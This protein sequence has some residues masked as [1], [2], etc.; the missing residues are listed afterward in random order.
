MKT[1]YIKEWL[2]S[3][4][5]MNVLLLICDNLIQNTKYEKYLRFFSGFL[6]MLCLVKPLV[7]FAGAE[8]YMDAAYIQNA[9]KNE[10]GLIGETEDF[11]KMKSEIQDEY[12]TAIEKQISQIAASYYIEIAE[13]HIQWN[14]QG[15]TVQKIDM[16][17]KRMEN[18]SDSPKMKSFREALIQ[19]YNLDDSNIN[20]EMRE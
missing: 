17:G 4:L 13:I 9:L 1:E 6:M 18:S 20:I 5:Y 15:D 2:K 12:E 10:I 19:F 7:D 14:S 3:I 11:K 16:E 8:T